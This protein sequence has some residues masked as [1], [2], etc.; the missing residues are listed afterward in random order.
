MF[1]S[2][3]RNRSNFELNYWVIYSFFFKDQQTQEPT[4]FPSESYLLSG[5]MVARSIGNLI[6]ILWWVLPAPWLLAF[7]TL[8]TFWEPSVH[9]INTVVPYIPLG[10]YKKGPNHGSPLWFNWR[11]VA[12]SYLE[13]NIAGVML[14]PIPFQCSLGMTLQSL[15]NHQHRFLNQSLKKR[16]CITFNLV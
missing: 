15:H 12:F 5:Q 11:S 6:N 10:H 16:V 2:P 8:Q 7:H 4:A 3:G 13:A 14:L 1:E 9:N